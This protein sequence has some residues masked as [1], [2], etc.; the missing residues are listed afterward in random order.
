MCSSKAAFSDLGEVL[1]A[2]KELTIFSAF[3]LIIGEGNE[4]EMTNI[5]YMN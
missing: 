4:K 3:V 5:P 2:R 1:K